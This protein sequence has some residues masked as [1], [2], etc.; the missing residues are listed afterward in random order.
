MPAI[1][2]FWSSSCADAT[3]FPWRTHGA[4]R[5]AGAWSGAGP[6]GFAASTQQ[7][8]IASCSG[9]PKSL[10][11]GGAGSLAQDHGAGGTT[12]QV[13]HH[14][15]TQLHQQTA[16]QPPVSSLRH[17]CILADQMYLLV[18]WL[19]QPPRL[20]QRTPILAKRLY[21]SREAQGQLRRRALLSSLPSAPT[22]AGPCRGTQS[23]PAA[24]G[25]DGILFP[26][27]GISR[28]LGYAA[29]AEGSFAPLACCSRPGSGREGRRQLRSHRA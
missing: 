28:R 21:S 12:S 20:P 18:S 23:C 1:K 24:A 29:L 15:P 13:L 8:L 26:G 9:E 17:A 22:S 27:A 16:A 4:P 6:Q 2:S 11:G 5:T 3:R 10:T 25:G 14:G 7:T 19:A